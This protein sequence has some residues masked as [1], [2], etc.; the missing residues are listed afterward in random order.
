M[1]ATTEHLL[2]VEDAQHTAEMTA[3]DSV[4]AMYKLSQQCWLDD[5]T[6]GWAPSAKWLAEQR[7]CLEEALEYLAE[8]EAAAA[9]LK[10]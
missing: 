3:Y 5:D 9:S 10:S 4:L 7:E 8:I 2:T 1:S 6:A